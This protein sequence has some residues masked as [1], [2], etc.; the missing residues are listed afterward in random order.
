MNAFH[1]AQLKRSVEEYEK[2]KANPDADEGMYAGYYQIDAAI[3][4]RYK[5]LATSARD[6]L[7]YKLYEMGA[8][9]KEFEEE[10]VRKLIDFIAQNTVLHSSGASPDSPYSMMDHGFELFQIMEINISMLALYKA[11]YKEITTQEGKRS[12]LSDQLK[13]INDASVAASLYSHHCQTL[14][15]RAEEYVTRLAANK[16]LVVKLFSKLGVG[17]PPLA[18]TQTVVDPFDTSIY[19]EDD[20]RAV[21]DSPAAKKQ[22]TGGDDA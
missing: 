9:T 14:A 15:D 10:D 16:E 6:F 19:D 5:H 3:A 8:V 17:L 1:L 18:V 11:G 13:V 20:Q 21:E 22:K 2:D 12:S 7:R 4:K